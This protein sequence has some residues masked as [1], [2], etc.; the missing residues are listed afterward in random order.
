MKK[1]V[2]S[3]FF[4]GDVYDIIGEFQFH[5]I[6]AYTT[7]IIMISDPILGV[8]LYD[9]HSRSVYTDIGSN[10]NEENRDFVR[11]PSKIFK[12][13]NKIITFDILKW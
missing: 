1:S 9:I 3:N 13:I 8:V 6:V 7:G 11:V 10:I 2:G 5:N 12:W 4:D